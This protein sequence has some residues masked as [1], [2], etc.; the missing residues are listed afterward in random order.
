MPHLSGGEGSDKQQIRLGDI[1]NV[2]TEGQG[3]ISWNFVSYSIKSFN[4]AEFAEFVN[5]HDDL[6]NQWIQVIDGRSE[7]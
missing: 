2:E 4:N 1:D 7:D 5:Q 3:I 6:C